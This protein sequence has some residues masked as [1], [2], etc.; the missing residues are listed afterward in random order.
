MLPERRDRLHPP[1]SSEGGFTMMKRSLGIGEWVLRGLGAA[2]LVAVVA[3]AFGLDTGFL[4]RASL[5]ST[6]SLEQGLLDELHRV[7]NSQPQPSV[8][9]SGGPVMMSGNPAM[10]MK[11][12]P[13]PPVEALPIEGPLPNL[14]GSVDWLNSLPPTGHPESGGQDER[15]TAVAQ[16]QNTIEMARHYAKGA[17]LRR[18]MSRVVTSFDAEVKRAY[19]SC[20]T[21]LRKMSNLMANAKTKGNKVN[22][23]RWLCGSGGGTRTPDT[24]IMIPLL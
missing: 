20:Q 2:V 8:V 4:T 7:A 16:G 11:A 3:I 6:T 14:S 24:R 1:S 15:V 17:D 18:K 21:K 10:M 9:L 19:R 22:N 23:M 12:K 5:A 13:A